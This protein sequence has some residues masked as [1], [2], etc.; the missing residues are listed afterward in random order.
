MQKIS[1]CLWLD[2]RERGTRSLIENLAKYL[3]D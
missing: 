3:Q 1:T 2:G